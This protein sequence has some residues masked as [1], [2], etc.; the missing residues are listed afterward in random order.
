[1]AEKQAERAR[2]GYTAKN[3]EWRQTGG[4]AIAPGIVGFVSAQN[5]REDK[6]ARLVQHDPLRRW[7][8]RSVALC[9]PKPKLLDKAAENFRS[10]AWLGV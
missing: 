7:L 4:S 3:R 10:R 6:R 9:P 2:T 5:A 8:T 1:M